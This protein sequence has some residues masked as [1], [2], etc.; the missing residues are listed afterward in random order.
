MGT[1]NLYI[2]ILQKMKVLNF[3]F[4]PGNMFMTIILL[5]LLFTMSL[6]LDYNKDQAG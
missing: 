2:T 5:T 6:N 1:Y 3:L 4:N